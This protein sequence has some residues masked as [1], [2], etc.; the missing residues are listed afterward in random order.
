MQPEATSAGRR[1]TMEQSAPAAPAAAGSRGWMRE[2][3][4]GCSSLVSAIGAM[5]AMECLLGRMRDLAMF[6][7]GVQAVVDDEARQMGERDIGCGDGG[8][9]G[10]RPRQ[11]FAG[12]LHRGFLYER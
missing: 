2:Y 12:R 6:P 3:R 10:G 7:P 4:R 8:A 9:I 11:Q 1:R 5:P